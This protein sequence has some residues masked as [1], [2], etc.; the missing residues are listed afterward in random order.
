MG[1]EQVKKK[2][3]LKFILKNTMKWKKTFKF[4]L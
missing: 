1:G 4:C 2:K 3:K